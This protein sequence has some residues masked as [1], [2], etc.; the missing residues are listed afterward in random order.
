[1]ALQCI[2]PF[3][4]SNKGQQLMRGQNATWA[5]ITQVTTVVLVARRQQ[6]DCRRTA[7]SV[8]GIACYRRSCLHFVAGLVRQYTI[9]YV[10]WYSLESTVHRCALEPFKF[11]NSQP[12]C[13]IVWFRGRHLVFSEVNRWSLAETPF[14]T[15]R[16]QKFENDTENTTK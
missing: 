2:R 16:G 13:V 12:E 10:L 1:M 8:C 3:V 5:A 11:H 6:L 7:A 4:W 9:M 15:V 14:S